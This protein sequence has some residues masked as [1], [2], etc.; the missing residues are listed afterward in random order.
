[1][2]GRQPAVADQ[3]MKLFGPAPTRAPSITSPKAVSASRSPRAATSP[4]RKDTT[5]GAGRIARRERPRLF[6]FAYYVENKD[7]LKAVPIS[8]RRARRYCPPWMHNRR[9]YTPLAPRSSSM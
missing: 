3:P 7:K 8:M 1:M 6:R 4:R 2:E 5:A 9:H